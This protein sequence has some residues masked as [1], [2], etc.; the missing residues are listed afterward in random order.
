MGNT[1]LVAIFERYG[2][3]G[4]DWGDLTFKKSKSKESA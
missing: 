3:K 4:K 2:Q 1:N